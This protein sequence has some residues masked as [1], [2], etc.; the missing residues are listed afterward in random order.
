VLSVPSFCCNNSS[1]HNDS[2]DQCDGN[3]N[4]R[5]RFGVNNSC[6]FRVP[7]W[8]VLLVAGIFRCA[9]SWGWSSWSRHRLTYDVKGCTSCP[10]AIPAHSKC[11]CFSRG[12]RWCFA[13]RLPPRIRSIRKS[14]TPAR[15]TIIIIS[16]CSIDARIGQSS[17]VATRVQRNSVCRVCWNCKLWLPLSPWAVDAVFKSTAARDVCWTGNIR[18]RWRRWLCRASGWRWRNTFTLNV[19]R[20]TASSISICPNVQSK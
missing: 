6:K 9:C 5:C 11:E 16:T 10:S 7:F 13:M 17:C 12:I 18:W 20:C 1:S 14:K 4:T 2:C 8:L 15:S 3:E 19:E